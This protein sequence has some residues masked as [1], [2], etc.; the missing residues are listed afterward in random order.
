MAAQT[1]EEWVTSQRWEKL[2]ELNKE[3]VVSLKSETLV[4]DR[5]VVTFTDSRTAPSRTAPAANTNVAVGAYMVSLPP[6]FT[7]ICDRI[8][9]E[10]ISSS[11]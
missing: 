7:S 8:P 5:L 11:I 9:V 2:L 4:G 10:L 3:G 1:R 6:N